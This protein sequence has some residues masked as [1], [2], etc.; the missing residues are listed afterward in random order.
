VE[1]LGHDKRA[2]WFELVD[3]TEQ[4]ALD[5]AR[6]LAAMQRL[7]TQLGLARAD[8]PVAQDA[9]SWSAEG[10]VPT[11]C[12]TTVADISTTPRSELDAR[13]QMLRSSPR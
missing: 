6:T 11:R 7:T 5:A 10:D 12:P 13:A 9:A 2:R 3:A 8:T 4:V 1:R